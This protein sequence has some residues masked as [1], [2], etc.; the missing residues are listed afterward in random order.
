MTACA[1]TA[2]C[3]RASDAAAKRSGAPCLIHPSALPVPSRMAAR[4][5]GLSLAPRRLLSPAG[6]IGAPIDL[7]P[8]SRPAATGDNPSGLSPLSS[9]TQRPSPPRGPL[10]GEGCVSQTP[11]TNS[12]L[13]FAAISL[14]STRLDT[15]PNRS[16]RRS[17]RCVINRTGRTDEPCRNQNK[18][19]GREVS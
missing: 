13:S 7:A 4:S 15:T 2:A 19:I 14:A 8:S 16:I 6:M 18:S 1:D 5:C 9:D 11:A 17:F 12:K 3:F 10:A